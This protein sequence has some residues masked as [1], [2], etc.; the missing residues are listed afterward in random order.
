MTKSNDTKLKLIIIKSTCSVMD[1]KAK[2]LMLNCYVA[3]SESAVSN[4][5]LSTSVQYS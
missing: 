3:V 2:V 1:T 4:I 5:N